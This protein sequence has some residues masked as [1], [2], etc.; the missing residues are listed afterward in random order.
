MATQRFATAP[1]RLGP[2]S[3]LKRDSNQMSLWELQEAMQHPADG[4]GG[5][6]APSPRSSVSEA[7]DYG[8][9]PRVRKQRTDEPRQMSVFD[10]TAA[11]DE[12]PSATSTADNTLAASLAELEAMTRVEES[13]E[14]NTG[15]EEDIALAALESMAKEL[16][17][18]AMKEPPAPSVRASSL[19]TTPRAAAASHAEEAA[20]L[21]A[22]G[23]EDGAALFP[24]LEQ[25]FS[26]AFA[27]AFDGSDPLDPDDLLAM[28]HPDALQEPAMV[29]AHLAAPC[30]VAKPARGGRG[31]EVLP[32]AAVREHAAPQPPQQ[33]PPRQRGRAEARP[34]SLD[35]SALASQL[36]DL[37]VGKEAAAEAAAGPVLGPSA[38]VGAPAAAAAAGR[39]PAQERKEWTA[40][41]DEL[42]RSGVAEW[43]CKWRKIAVLLPG[44]SDDAV[45][46]RWH[47]LT[48]H[49]ADAAAAEG[50]AAPPM[51]RRRV[52]GGGRNA[53]VA[54][55]GEGKVERMSWTP[56]E[57]AIILTSVRE[58]GHK[59]NKI[60]T[61]LHGRTEHAIRNRYHRLQTALAD[62]HVMQ[63]QA[64]E[65][66]AMGAALGDAMGSPP[67]SPTGFSPAM[68]M[69]VGA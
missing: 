53:A 1:A 52:S 17:A 3:S 63:M 69:S 60:A 51:P 28:L 49:A 59:W 55:G 62:Q 58:L 18:D 46:N 19:G 42:I 56:T 31:Y 34:E 22:V 61:K 66:D 67:L 54:G 20:L 44:R 35:P 6:E 29:S 26:S 64:E 14:A 21:E 12:R 10:I 68:L 15:A 41:E 36:H 8:S 39:G 45:R 48:P 16:Q 40:A 65:A 23:A 30:V 2:R 25:Q 4:P 33:Q 32:A 47:R 50:A 38:G 11:F 5:S 43:G 24:R 57:D 27:S 9:W 13:A 37:G 7:T